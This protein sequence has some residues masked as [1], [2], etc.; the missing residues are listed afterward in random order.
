MFLTVTDPLKMK[1]KNLN[2]T[3]YFNCQQ[4]PPIRISFLNI[5]T[6]LTDIQSQTKLLCANN[7]ELLRFE[8]ISF[9]I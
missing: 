9:K 2:W 5:N 6:K 4:N 3:K 7:H 1:K 8:R